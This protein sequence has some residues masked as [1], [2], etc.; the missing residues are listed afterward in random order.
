MVRWG[1]NRSSKACPRPCGCSPDDPVHRSNSGL[2]NRFFM[3]HVGGGPSVG[4][5]CQSPSVN[6]SRF[7]EPSLTADSL[8]RVAAPLS[9]SASSS[10]VASGCSAL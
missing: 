3:D 4:A 5:P 6:S 1:W 2:L 8:F 9:Q 10:G 7:G